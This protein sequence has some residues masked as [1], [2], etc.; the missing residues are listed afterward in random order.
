[1][2]TTLTREQVEM[3]AMRALACLAIAVQEDIARDVNNKCMAYINALRTQLATVTGERDEAQSAP[4]GYGSGS[5]SCGHNSYWK[6]VYDH[7]MVCRA[8]KAEQQLATATV[9]VEALEGALKDAI[10][11]YCENVGWTAQPHPNTGEPCQV[12][13]EW[14]YNKQALSP[15]PPAKEEAP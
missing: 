2:T 10:C 9:R 5:L 14:C 3:E 13:C 12:Q 6:T 4:G 11:P 15:P 1:M 8:E 7:C